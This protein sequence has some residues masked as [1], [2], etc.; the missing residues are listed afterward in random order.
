M[1]LQ[2]TT[3]LFASLSEYPGHEENI[4]R[5]CL[6]LFSKAGSDYAVEHVLDSFKK[7]PSMSQIYV[8]YLARFIEVR[9][10]QKF[11]LEQLKDSALFDWQR[12]WILAARSQAENADD[13]SVKVA[14]DLL[15]DANRHEALRAV[16]AIYV[17][18]FGDHTRRKALVAIYPSVSTYI[19]AAIYYASRRWPPVERS[20]AK[21]SWSG[22]SPL[23]T[24]LTAA[25]TKK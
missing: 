12:I 3:V 14:F 16:A 8:A 13:T 10:A 24:L 23:H 22:H 5:F 19:Q 1:E 21:A 25:L 15:R 2:A 18:R 7:R 11:L 17:G 20:N 4:E 6:P 9:D